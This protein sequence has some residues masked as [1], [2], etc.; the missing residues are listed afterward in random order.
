M[1]NNISMDRLAKIQAIQDIKEELKKEHK[2]MLM[3]KK[4]L[5]P[6]MD[7]LVKRHYIIAQK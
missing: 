6:I 2:H 7:R 1:S 5:N 3:F 4:N